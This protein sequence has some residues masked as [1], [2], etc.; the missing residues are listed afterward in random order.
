[1]E[2]RYLPQIANSKKFELNMFVIAYIV[3]KLNDLK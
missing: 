3:C 2:L 1:M